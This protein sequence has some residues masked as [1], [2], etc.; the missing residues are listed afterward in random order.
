MRRFF[1]TPFVIF[2]FVGL[3]LHVM[4]FWLCGCGRL[5][6]LHVHFVTSGPLISVD[7][8]DVRARFFYWI[9]FKKVQKGCVTFIMGPIL[10]IKV[11]CR[12]FFFSILLNLKH[13]F[14]YGKLF[15]FYINNHC[16]QT[17]FYSKLFDFIYKKCRP[18]WFMSNI[19]NYQLWE[20]KCRAIIIHDIGVVYIYIYIYKVKYHHIPLV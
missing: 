7:G 20:D 10:S 18:S 12:E 5:R 1:V 8:C 2:T 9:K 14:Q 3:R 13:M 11:A 19:L 17:N 15:S 6:C 16:M 4:F